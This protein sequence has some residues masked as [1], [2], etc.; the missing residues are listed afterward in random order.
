MMVMRKPSTH[1]Q[2]GLS[3]VNM[4]LNTGPVNCEVY[5]SSSSSIRLSDIGNSPWIKREDEKDEG[6]RMKDE[7]P[8]RLICLRLLFCVIQSSFDFRNNSYEYRG[9]FVSFLAERF[10]STSGALSFTVMRA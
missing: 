6:G 3:K 1:F 7:D 8:L 9:K 5:S 2:C 10:K 4:R